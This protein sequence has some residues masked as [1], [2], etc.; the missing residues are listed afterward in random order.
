MW[1]IKGRPVD[2]KRFTPF[3]PLRVLNYYDGPRIFTF[4]DADDALCLACWSDEDEE[5][6]R[7]LVVAATDQII[8][9]LEGGLLSVREALAQPRL[10]VVDWAQDGTLTS[11]WL[12]VLGDVPEDSQPQP[13]TMLHRSLDPILALRATGEAIRPGEIPGSVIKGTVEGAQ[14]A[15]KCLAEYEM[16]LPT[17]K[18]RPSRALQKLY[19]LPVQKTLAASFEVQFRSPLNEPGLFEGLGES[20]IRDEREVLGRV[21]DHL[22][23][24]LNWL[25]ATSQAT[26]A[27][28]A[29]DN[30]DLSRAIIKALK[31]LTPPPHG[32]IR[33]MEVR[34]EL[35]TH[36]AGPVR[37]SRGTRSILNGAMS[38]IPVTKERRVELSGRI[39]ELNERL[40]RFEL[41]DVKHPPA[42]FRVCE[43]EAEFWDDVYEMLGVEETVKVFG[44]ETGPTSVVRVIDLIRPDA[45]QPTS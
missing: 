27:L 18:G 26:T 6:S 39:R 25:T 24:G 30:P 45:A 40:L 34:G 9:D 22:R 3:E 35:A 10:W 20:E 12:G 17:R 16:D 15:I 4:H 7:F 43:F 14:R 21:A 41:H 44:I 42:A 23:A 19:D 31:F 2:P 8:A 37:L 29:P 38:R 33:E 28:P 13:R 32:P 36:T 1:E 11:A 5:N